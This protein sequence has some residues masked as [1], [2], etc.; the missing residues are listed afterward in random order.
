MGSLLILGRIRTPKKELLFF[1][2]IIISKMMPKLFT[3]IL[4]V[5]FI[6]CTFAEDLDLQGRDEVDG[7]E[8]PEEME[9]GSPEVEMNAIRSQGLNRGDCIPSGSTCGPHGLPC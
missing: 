5:A 8:S 7:I 4:V 9:L 6:G 1:E 2:T 3:F